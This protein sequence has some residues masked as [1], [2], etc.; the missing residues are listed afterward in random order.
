MYVGTHLITGAHHD[1]HDGKALF[2]RGSRIWAKTCFITQTLDGVASDA[3]NSVAWGDGLVVTF[4]PGQGMAL[5]P[6]TVR[7]TMGGTDVTS[8]AFDFGT[9]KITLASVTG[10][11][12]IEAIGAE[13][14]A[15]VEYIE[16]DGYPRINTGVKVAPTTTFHFEMYINKPNRVVQPFG[17]RTAY[18]SNAMSV[19]ND[20]RSGGAD[21]ATWYYGNKSQNFTLISEGWHIFDNTAAAN[22]LTV[23]NTT[24]AVTGATMA[25]TNEDFFIFT[26]NTGGGSG[27]NSGGG[28]KS[29]GG[30]MYSSGTLVRDYIPVR[31]DGVG[32]LY[33]TVTK[34]LFGN[35]NSSGA[36]TYGNDK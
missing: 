2:F 17:G 13:V 35:A 28:L 18:L 19:A 4:T 25:S 9:R 3:P 34:N 24:V 20:A 5:L 33:D 29:K 16:A 14:D 22:K 1:G 26:I 8:T 27:G 7:V 6:S 30:K 32:Y 21:T 12:A 10:D 11:V 23:D 36:F 31:K 15:E